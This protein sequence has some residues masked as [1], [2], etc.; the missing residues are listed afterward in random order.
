M[1]RMRLF[2]E[3]VSL[4]NGLILPILITTTGIFGFSDIA[5]AR[6]RKTQNSQGC[7]EK[8][9]VSL[10]CWRDY[11][12]KGEGSESLPL[13][14]YAKRANGCSVPMAPPGKY[15]NFLSNGYNFSFREVC[16]QH[17][18]CYFTLGTRPDQCNVPFARNL[19][20]VCH[21]G[22]EQKN[23]AGDRS[24]VLG[25]SPKKL[26]AYYACEERAKWMAEAVISAQQIY[27]SQSQRI[28]QNYLN[29][30]EQYLRRKR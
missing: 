12:G 29:K 15:D 1:P 24:L 4:V 10:P 3:K 11:L 16:N 5:D 2:K 20:K 25:V 9:R 30:V 6:P 27:H 26:L 19:K 17:D 14:P 18:R 22:L 8:N 28:Q 21:N 7:G 23:R 13:Y